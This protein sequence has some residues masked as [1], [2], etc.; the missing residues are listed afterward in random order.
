LLYKGWELTSP[1]LKHKTMTTQITHYSI[2][3]KNGKIVPGLFNSMQEAFREVKRLG[4]G[5]QDVEYRSVIEHIKI[6]KEKVK[7]EKVKKEK[8]K[9]NMLSNEILNEVKIILEKEFNE[10][11][12]K[13]NIQALLKGKESGH[14]LASEVETRASEI[15][16]K[17]N[18]SITYETHDSGKKNGT[19]KDRANSDFILDGNRINVKFSSEVEG[20]PNIC[21][22]KRLMDGLVSGE[23]DGYYILKVKYDRITEKLSIYFFDVLD[24]LDVVE[25][26][27][28]PG[29]TMLKEKLFYKKYENKVIQRKTVEEKIDSLFAMYD[30]KILE[31]IQLK[32]KQRDEYSRKLMDYKQKITY[33]NI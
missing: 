30:K 1:Q 26:N 24:C 7:K 21:S 4:F 17:Y 2:H 9:S 22:I 27:G 29:Q 13:P 10:F 15:L 5:V 3:P 6:K 33:L 8:I 18:Y 14:T 19:R 28:G 31:H 32:Q 25:Y 16:E 23:I 12:K 11:F 20:Q